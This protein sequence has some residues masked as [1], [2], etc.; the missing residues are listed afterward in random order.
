[1]TFRAAQAPH[2]RLLDSTRFAHPPGI[3]DPTGEVGATRP[4]TCEPLDDSE[5][6]NA[7]LEATHRANRAGRIE[8]Q[9]DV[10]G[11]TSGA[12]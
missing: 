7:T 9:D 12:G 8:L 5:Y 11:G 10:D 2:T 1:M 3:T 4:K 6:A